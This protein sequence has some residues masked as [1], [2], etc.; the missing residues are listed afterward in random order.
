MAETSAW[1]LHNGYLIVK[2]IFNEYR[3]CTNSIFALLC[4][5]Y[6]FPVLY[7]SD[8]IIDVVTYLPYSYQTKH[9][10]EERVSG[11][12]VCMSMR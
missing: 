8:V 11:S 3:H 5:I 1:R 2:V 7:S 4:W 6:I 10:I 9:G 12:D